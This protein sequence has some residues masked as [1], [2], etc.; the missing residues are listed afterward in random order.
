MQANKI[1]GFIIKKCVADLKL[2]FILF[3]KQLGLVAGAVLIILNPKNDIG[4]QYVVE[5]ISFWSSEQTQMK[6]K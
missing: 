4:Q 2:F 3:C 1:S 6:I 5:I